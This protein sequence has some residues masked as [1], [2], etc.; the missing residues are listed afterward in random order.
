MARS[1]SPP[2]TRNAHG[3]DGAWPMRTPV[4]LFWRLDHGNC[5]RRSIGASIAF[6]KTD[7][8]VLGLPSLFQSN[9]I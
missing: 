5:H 1:F 7:N 3:H 8:F 2:R 4:W 6:R 9:A